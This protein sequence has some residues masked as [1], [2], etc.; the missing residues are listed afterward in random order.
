MEGGGGV[1]SMIQATVSHELRT[2]LNG[3]LGVVQI[4]QKRIQG[5]ELLHFLSICKKSSHLLIGLVNS[6]LDL[7]QIRLKKLELRPEKN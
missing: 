5:P 1:T 4:M 7:N 2:S 6:I 3:I